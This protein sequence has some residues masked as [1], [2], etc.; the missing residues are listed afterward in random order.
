MTKISAIITCF[1]VEEYIAP[2]MQSILD[3]QFDDLELIVVDDCSTDSTRSIADLIGAKAQADYVPIHF[4]KNTIGGVASAANAGLDAATGDLVIFIDGD[5]WVV[6][7]ALREAVDIQID[8]GS[9]FTLCNCAE[10]W[11]GNGEYTQYPEAHHWAKIPTLKT[12]DELVDTVLDMAPFPWRKIYRR[13]FLEDNAIRFPVGDY[14]FEDNP[15][16]W[17]TTIRAQKIATQ[18]KV[19]HIHRMARTGQTVNAI[20]PRALKIFEH[21]AYIHKVLNTR[22]EWD[23]YSSRYMKWLLNHV[24]WAGREV[25]AGYLNTVYEQARPLLRQI[26][27]PMFWQALALS[28]LDAA[29]C[30]KLIAVYLGQRF[31]FLREF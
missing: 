8:S 17:D 27:E 18:R 15:F 21:A 26:D 5:D 28:G 20:G 2:A 6:P 7:A 12:R 19:T 1:N 3:C 23:R 31:D 22:K 25:P 30:R 13:D 10:Y 11:N 9:D 16:H 14:F 24:L 29:D 4:S